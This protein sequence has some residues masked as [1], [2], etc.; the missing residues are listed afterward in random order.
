MKERAIE[1][2]MELDVP[3]EAL[4]AAWTTEE[5]VLSFFSPACNVELR[6]G[7]PY[8]IFF[9]MDAPAGQ[10]GGEEMI[11]LAFQE[12]S[13]LSFT[14]NAPPNLAEVR[15]QRSHVTIRFEALG[16]QKT[17]LHFREDG[18]GEGGEW[19]ERFDYFVRAWGQV[20]LPRLAYRIANGP[21]DWTQDID[22]APFQAVVKTS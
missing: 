10:R 19:N 1:F 20:V 14:W 4:W 8:E 11:V 17:R 5:G 6:P 16:E 21:V 7:G 18:F 3:I 22:L 15:S 2:E 12:P 13:M 9:N